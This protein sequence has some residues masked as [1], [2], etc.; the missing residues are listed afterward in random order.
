MLAKYAIEALDT[1]QLKIVYYPA[2]N[3]GG[4]VATGAPPTQRKSRHRPTIGH[5]SP[6]A[7]IT[8]NGASQAILARF[9]ARDLGCPKQTFWISV[10]TGSSSM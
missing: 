4:G 1:A 9:V 8:D 2:V 5:V 6:S 3:P 10:K 7:P